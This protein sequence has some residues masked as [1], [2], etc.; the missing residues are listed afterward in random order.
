MEVVRVQGKNKK[1]KVLIY[2]ISTCG[3]CKRTK[4]FLSDIGIEYGYVD[5]DL[6]SEEDREM[7]RNEIR[8]LK[9]ELLYPTMII[10][11]KVLIQGFQ[12]DKIKEL[13]AF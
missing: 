10:D 1:H 9:G 12:E 8:R 5:I 4:K 7:I 13:L 11:D 2:T 6:C 3:W